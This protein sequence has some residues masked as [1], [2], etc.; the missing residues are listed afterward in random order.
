[1][2][3]DAGMVAALANELNIKLTGARIDKIQQPEKEEIVFT[4]RAE[5]ENVRLSLS[6]G[7]N[8]P[9]VNLT[10]ITKEN[11]ASAPMFCMLLRKHL[12]GGRILQV[13]QYDFERVIEIAL[14]CRD[15]MGFI[16]TKY[17]IVEI[18]GK[19]SN[20]IFCD[21]NK[22]IISAIKPVDFTTS[23]KRQVLA[24]MTY[25]YPP[26]QDKLSP[27]NTTKEEFVGLFENATPERLVSRFIVDN[28]LGISNLVAN[29]IAYK[30]S[31]STDTYLSECTALGLWNA[32]NEVI[33]VIKS[34]EFT[35][36]ILKEGDKPAE[37]SF[38]SINQ[39]GGIYNQI[40]CNTF[41]ELIDE[42]YV[43]KE[44][45]NHIKQISAD[46]SKFLLN[47]ENRIVKKISIHKEEIKRA[48]ENLKNKTIGDII[49]AN[50]YMLKRGDTKVKLFDYSLDE[51]IERV[52]ELD[53]KLSPSQNAQRYY[54]RYNKAK[55]AISVLTEHLKSDETELEYIRSVLDAL[56]RAE[57]ET[58]LEEIRRELKTAGYS[59]KSKMSS[60]SNIKTVPFEFKTENGYTVLCGR[61]NIQNDMLTFKTASKLD[62]W[63]HVKNIAGSHCI[64]I[65]NGEE[66]P[67]IDFTQA[68]IIAA[69]HSKAAEGE[70]VAVDYTFVKNVKKINAAKPGLVTYSTNW[71]AYVNPDEKICE[72]LRVR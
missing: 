60:K 69:T 46:L 67:E 51:P 1:M 8:N 70:N 18:M 55:K 11:P 4:L 68:A 2:A 66:P 25:E 61:N 13:S 49:T 35:P 28:Y 37:F 43:K 41:S 72:K 16:C 34:K 9:R 56:S 7:A 53:S 27:L 29:E 65:C 21:E 47:N 23:S 57:G 54:K 17:I 22:K 48:N 62:Y 31:G 59:V 63:F 30:A 20:I 19:Y 3:F 39:Y 71:T 6:S 15:E 42:Y 10:S 40:K 52:I 50:I 26:K 36:Y 32:F 58:D 45:I 33:S 5:R 44:R 24:G 12:L 14:E 38:I 64:L